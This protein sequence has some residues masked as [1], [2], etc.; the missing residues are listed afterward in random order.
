V[1]R[2]LYALE[3][4]GISTT[5]I[6]RSPIH[7]CRLE[8]LEEAIRPNTKM[9]IWNHASNVFGTLS[10][11]DGLS[12]LA[13]AYR[14]KI[15]IDAAQTVGSIPINMQEMGIEYLACS[16][17]KGLYGPQGIG[18]LLMNDP[19]SGL[20]VW[21][22]GE[23]GD[24]SEQLPMPRKA[25]D[26]YE[27][28]TPNLPGIAGL[29]EGV[30]FVIEQGLE[31]MYQSDL[32]KIESIYHALEDIEGVVLYG[33]TPGIA[34]VPIL[35]FNIVGL[36]AAQVGNNYTSAGIFRLEPGFNL[37]TGHTKRLGPCPMGLYELA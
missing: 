11:L 30:D 10:D 28:G 29:S 37:L 13:Q 24:F 31:K 15:L 36:T 5:K 32:Q 21:K 23:T 1:A 4:Q 26:C 25:P 35:S 6:Y 9:I 27:A 7:G 34:K 22:Y 2:T 19:D 17:H 33:P 12:R 20:D 14:L 3:K 8:R 16:G 18:L